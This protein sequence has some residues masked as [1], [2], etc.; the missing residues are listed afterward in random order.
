MDDLKFEELVKKAMVAFNM[1]RDDAEEYV[2]IS[3]GLSV[4]DVIIVPDDMID[5]EEEDSDVVLQ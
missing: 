5:D 2:A 1:S 4:G 3:E